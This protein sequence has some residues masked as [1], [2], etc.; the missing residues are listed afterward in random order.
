M[1][2]TCQCMSSKNPISQAMS[3][4]LRRSDMF[5]WFLHD[6]CIC[7]TNNAAER[8]LGGIALG[9]KAPSYSPGQTGAEN[10]LLPCIP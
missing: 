8:A 5:T 7:L 3:Y 10:A 1:R 4:F 9:R 6:G 2:D